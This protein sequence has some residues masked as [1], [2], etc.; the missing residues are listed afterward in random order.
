MFSELLFNRA[1]DLWAKK[2]RTEIIWVL[3]KS[4]MRFS[5]IKQQLPGCSVKM[6]SES[7]QEMEEKDLLTRTQYS[8]IPVKV[9]YELHQD[10]I[11]LIPSLTIY[12]QFL[13]GYF[14]TNREKF[15]ITCL[16][17]IREL[18]RIQLTGE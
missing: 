15:N 10:V 9:T 4:P 12:R 7:L 1:N 18:E 3:R 2:W 16:E 8:T 6:L 14:L 17:D 11:L 5:Q 13:A